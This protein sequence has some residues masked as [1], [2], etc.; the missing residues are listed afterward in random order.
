VVESAGSQPK[1]SVQARTVGIIAPGVDRVVADEAQTLGRARP[2][3]FEEWKL[4][5]LATYELLNRKESHN[6]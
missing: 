4:S 1:G 6:V 5:S 2:L 3:V